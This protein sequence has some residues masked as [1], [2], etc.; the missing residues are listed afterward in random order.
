MGAVPFSVRTV[1]FLETQFLYNNTFVVSLPMSD[2]GGFFERVYEDESPALKGKRKPC[3][4]VS[5]VRAL[6]SWCLFKGPFSV[7]F[8]QRMRASHWCLTRLCA[9]VCPENVLTL[10]V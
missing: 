9:M 7:S 5:V 10:L 8:L 1:G 6:E 4:L 2:K 3:F